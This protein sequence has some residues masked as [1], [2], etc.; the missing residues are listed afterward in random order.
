MEKY[1]GEQ[2]SFISQ[3]TNNLLLPL[4]LTNLLIFF[5]R[6]FSWLLSF[7]EGIAKSSLLEHA[8]DQ[9]QS[10]QFW[11]VFNAILRHAKILQSGKRMVYGSSCFQ[12]LKFF[13][14]FRRNRLFY[15]LF[16]HSKNFSSFVGCPWK[17]SGCIFHGISCV[18]LDHQN[19]LP[20]LP[21]L[22]LWWSQQHFPQLEGAVP[23]HF[24]SPRNAL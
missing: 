24:S 23:L 5:S 14:A 8:L 16:L 11:H 10:L 20:E 17:Y 19:I 21:L 7:G 3:T 6:L 18:E 12:G 2:H 4:W 13:L 22:W 15:R 9:D 1:E